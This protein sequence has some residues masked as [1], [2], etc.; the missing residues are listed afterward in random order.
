MRN[1]IKVTEKEKKPSFD[2]I[3]HTE[4]VKKSKSFNVVLTEGGFILLSR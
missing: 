1:E 4:V 3:Q 2:N